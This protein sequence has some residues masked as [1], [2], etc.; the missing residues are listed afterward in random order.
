MDIASKSILNF[1]N[2]VNPEARLYC[3]HWA[4][5]N[6]NA[7]KIWG[8]HFEQANIELRAIMLP[9]RLT[10]SRE[11]PLLTVQ[12]IVGILYH[13]TCH[14]LNIL[15][16]L[17]RDMRLLQLLG[18]NQPPCV[19]FGHSFGGLIAYE[20]VRHLQQENHLIIKHLIISSTNNPAVLS[21]RATSCDPAIKKFHKMTNE[22]LFDH[23]IASG[24]L[25]TGV[26]PDFLR[27]ALPLIKAD[28]TALETY[29]TSSPVLLECA[30]SVFGGDD[31]KEVEQASLL[32]WQ[33]GYTT[34]HVEARLFKGNHFY[35]QGATTK[36]DV[37]EALKKICLK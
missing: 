29:V 34:Q 1:T 31:D 12:Q 8:T 32:G 30:M 19:F 18:D 13:S 37:L 22:A 15:D 7:F 35:F 16:T 9:G 14:K 4:G 33:H 26:H 5:S 3:F 10:R 6:A 28:Y 27:M 17:I 25:Q 20:L 24:G 2:V 23:I 21:S 11:A 36:N